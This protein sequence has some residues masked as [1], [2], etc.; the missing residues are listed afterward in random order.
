M[1]TVAVSELLGEDFWVECGDNG[2]V[3]V[4]VVDNHH[5]AS[6]LHQLWMAQADLKRE[7]YKTRLVKKGVFST[8]RVYHTSL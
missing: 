1:S 6:T 5:E 8:L 3:V 7:G 4:G 2:V